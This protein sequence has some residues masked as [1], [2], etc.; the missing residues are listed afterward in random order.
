MTQIS[1]TTNAPLV[2]QGL[3]NLAAE[4]PQVGRRR[5]YNT[6][7]RVLVRMRKYPKER[8]NQK[9]IRRYRLQRNWKLKKL[10]TGYTVINN[11]P[12]TK[13]VVGT[14]YGTEQAWMHVS[15]DQGKRWQLLRDEVEAEIKT[16][17]EE[18][19]DEIKLVARRNKL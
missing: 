9:Y 7:N 13:Y 8:K 5:I 16:L 19:E 1:I 18:I 15:T 14:A 10:E 6:S 4:I 17:P 11:T 12:Y 3:E 2:R